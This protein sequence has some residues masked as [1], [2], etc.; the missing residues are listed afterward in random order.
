MNVLKESSIFKTEREIQELVKKQRQ[1]FFSGKTLPLEYRIKAL[2]SLKKVII[3]NEDK[4]A[5]AIKKDLGKSNTEGFM[6]EIGLVLSEINYMIRNIRSFAKDKTVH[7]NLTQFAA[8]SYV[9]SVPYGVTLIISPW[10]YPFLLSIE[11][12]VDTLAAGNT[13][14]IKPSEYSEATSKIIEE[15]ITS[16][17]PPEYVSVVIGTKEESIYLLNQKFD[18]I[19]FTG[20]KAVGKYVMNK[21]SEN[22]TPVTDRKSVV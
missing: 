1:F 11:P 13:A 21:A 15:L 6:C 14:I 22:L 7:T 17:F 16:I 19:F 2:K 9:K 20:S 10:N 3:E 4:I 12:L 5:Q 8:R 18:Y